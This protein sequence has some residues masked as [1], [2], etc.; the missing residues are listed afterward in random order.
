M[1]ATPIRKGTVG[2]PPR[3]LSPGYRAQ[4][5]IVRGFGWALLALVLLIA[6]FPV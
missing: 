1:T 6:L 4:K 2:P 3:R 5:L